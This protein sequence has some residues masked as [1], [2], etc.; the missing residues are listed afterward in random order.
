MTG[1][2]PEA[3]L[4]TITSHPSTQLVSASHT[5]PDKLYGW[6]RPRATTSAHTAE[7]YHA[8]SWFFLCALAMTSATDEWDEPCSP[9]ARLNSLN[10]FSVTGSA[11]LAMDNRV[12]VRCAITVARE[13][14]ARKQALD[15]PT[16]SQAMISTPFIT[17]FL[18]GSQRQPDPTLAG[19]P[20]DQRHKTP[21]LLLDTPWRRSS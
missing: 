1:M 21:T 14:Q 7:K 20:F 3:P 6:D 17:H 10:S 13:I 11:P 12:V 8:S 15:Q 18:I 2:P 5:H 4:H 16:V 19:V 9:M